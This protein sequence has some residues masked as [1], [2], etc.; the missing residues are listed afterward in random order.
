MSSEAGPS[1]SSATTGP[2]P[3]PV[4]VPSTTASEAT[5]AGPPG[6]SPHNAG[7][8]TSSAGGPSNASTASPPHSSPSFAA[9]GSSSSRPPP[10]ASASTS[11]L[12]PRTATTA[13]TSLSHINPNLPSAST[14]THIAEARAALVGSMSNLLDS[15]LQS[16]AGLLHSNAAALS[17]QEADVIKATEGLRR[18]N[19]KL[20]KVAKEAGKRIKETGNVQNWAEVLE[21]DFMVLEETL[22]RVREGSTG[23]EGSGSYTG[24]GSWSGSEAGSARGSAPISAG[25]GGGAKGP[26]G[27]V[28]D[29]SG[30]GG[31]GTVE[32]KTFEDVIVGDGDAGGL[33]DLDPDVAAELDEHEGTFANVD[34]AI[35]NKISEAMATS[36]DDMGTPEVHADPSVTETDSQDKS[37]GREIAEAE[38][39]GTPDVGPSE[40]ME[41]DTRGGDGA[42]ELVEA[43]ATNV[44]VPYPSREMEVDM[45]VTEKSE[46]A[47]GHADKMDMEAL[48]PIGLVPQ[49]SDDHKTPMT[50]ESTDDTVPP[51]EKELE[52]PNNGQEV[53]DGDKMDVDDQEVEKPQLEPTHRKESPSSSTNVPPQP[54]MI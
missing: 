35:A 53:T 34:N 2:E 10:S 3:V 41:T 9:T 51:P 19:D 50:T 52:E 1:T 38:V 5:S 14:A 45:D 40:E 54:A 11:Q 49:T 32:K 44:L 8:S 30:E 7:T 4:P 48:E 42:A 47:A 22:R 17:K 15:E 13:S 39:V 43:D 29:E 26:E 27:D 46:E 33:M 21:R 36:L 23:S 16:R 31:K 24:S 28:P 37:K 18:E 12:S 6:S 20:A 25:E